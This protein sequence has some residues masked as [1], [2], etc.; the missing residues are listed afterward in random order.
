MK[1]RVNIPKKIADHFKNEAKLLWPNEHYAILI[2]ARLGGDVF[3][4]DSLFY[5]P[6]FLIVSSPTHLDINYQSFDLAKKHADS[7][8]LE[9]LGDI[10]SH[11][12]DKLAVN[13]NDCGPSE[14]DLDQ[15]IPPRRITAG[16]TTIFGICTIWKR[17]KTMRSRIR[18]WPQIPQIDTHIEE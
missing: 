5:P 12:Y 6:E 10:H 17:P 13:G 14:I 8:G 16:Q 3:E 2:G 1:I 15:C 4:I 11:C 7:M 18:F 9:V